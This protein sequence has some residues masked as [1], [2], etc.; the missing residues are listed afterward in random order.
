MSDSQGQIP[1]LAFRFKCLKLF[2]LFTLC[3]E[4]VHLI[5]GVQ[6][7]VSEVPQYR[8]TSLKMNSP[9]PLEPP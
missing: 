2:E 7:V 6:F 4:A 9:P 8:G 1:A 5:V 3:L